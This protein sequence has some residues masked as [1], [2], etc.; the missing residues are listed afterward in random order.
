MAI[1]GFPLADDR[2][3]RAQ[4]AY[5][6]YPYHGQI[7][8]MKW[9]RKRG[10]P[11]QA[12]QQASLQ[13]IKDMVRAYKM[14]DSSVIATAREAG[15]LMRVRPQDRFT[16][17]SSG[18]AYMIDRPGQTSLYPRRFLYRVC[19]ALDGVCYAPRAM[20]VRTHKGWYPL[21]GGSAGS[22]MIMTGG[23]PAWSDGTMVDESGIVNSNTRIISESLDAIT[24]IPGS[25]MY[26]DRQW[27]M[28]IPPGDEGDILTMSADGT[29]RWAKA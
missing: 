27:W 9:P 19:S 2:P 24:Q 21:P 20:P 15:S 17:V 6:A 23:M 3:S 26:R 22:H 16:H 28:P 25:L 8:A 29:P 12:H 5:V 14:S 13:W 18:A 7:R 1:M 4:K 11:K 10:A